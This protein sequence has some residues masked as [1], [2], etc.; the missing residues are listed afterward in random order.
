MTGSELDHITRSHWVGSTP[1]QHGWID[2]PGASLSHLLQCCVRWQITQSGKYI[3]IDVLSNDFKLFSQSMQVI[4]TYLSVSVQS[5]LCRRLNGWLVVHNW[6]VCSCYTCFDECITVGAKGSFSTA[7]WNVSFNI[8]YCHSLIADHGL[9]RLCELVPTTT[10]YLHTTDNPW[11]TVLFQPFLRYRPVAFYWGKTCPWQSFWWVIAIA[12][13][14]LG[15]I[16][17]LKS[18]PSY[19]CAGFTE[20]ICTQ[21]SH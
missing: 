11:S 4:M 3:T 2:V 5:E 8:F 15:Y 7:C 12:C 17:W 16:A 18:H 13:F 20:T 21:L 14:D 19:G 10:I 6:L 1:T 9:R